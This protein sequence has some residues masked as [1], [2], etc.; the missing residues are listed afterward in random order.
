MFLPQS[1]QVMHTS[2]ADS[3]SPAVAHLSA[4]DFDTFVSRDTQPTLVEFGAAWCGPCRMQAPILNELARE[5]AGRARVAA[6][7]VDASPELAARFGIR[8]LPTLAFFKDGQLRGT[9]VG[10][11]AKATLANELRSLA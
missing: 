5:F 2:T 8:S 9:L 6:V 1:N 7:D 4:E 10:L 3:S 11:S